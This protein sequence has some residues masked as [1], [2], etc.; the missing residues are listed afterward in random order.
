MAGATSLV[1]L[2][3][4]SGA[5]GNCTTGGTQVQSGV[6]SDGD[7]VLDSAEVSAT[8]YVCDGS[9]GAPGAPGAPGKDGATGPAGPAGND[10]APG[11]AGKDGASSLIAMTPEAA[12]ANCATGGTRIDAGVDV[13]GDGVLAGDEVRQTSY[14]C[15][16]P[17]EPV[18]PPAPDAGTCAVDVLF[19][20]DRSGSMGGNLEAGA[21]AKWQAIGLALESFVG[22]PGNA[23]LNVGLQ[24]FPH[25]DASGSDS[26]SQGDY[27]TPA[28][29]MGPASMASDAFAS[30]LDVLS[31][32]GGAPTQVAL[33][34]AINYAAAKH[35]ARPL[36]KVHVVL[37]TDGLSTECDTIGTG[38]D[39]L[40]TIAG[41]AP[42]QGVRLS[43][44][45][46]DSAVNSFGD[47]VARLGGG[48]YA[49]AANLAS[50]VDAV[51]SFSSQANGCQ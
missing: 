46:V 9:A 49:L 30:V 31:P 45:G 39:G 1:A 47:S 34:T 2:L 43:V 5:R 18:P 10:G 29:P 36:D 37:I 21:T 4:F 44:I 8:A 7:G 50:L 12:G 51:N 27:A 14:V 22:D 20:V 40:M 6:D 23:S 24:Y 11:A 26:C 33:L 3:P 17:N 42:S 16:G 19:L 48:Y 35:R 38:E 32:A 15:N 41:Q 13:N 25:Q 28:V